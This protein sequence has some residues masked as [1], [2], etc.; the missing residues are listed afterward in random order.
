MQ[1]DKLPRHMLNFCMFTKLSVHWAYS[2]NIYAKESR[3]KSSVTHS[4]TQVQLE[5]L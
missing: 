4:P 1:A 2:C 3:L 5:M